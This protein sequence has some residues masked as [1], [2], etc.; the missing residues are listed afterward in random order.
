[1]GL[2][3]NLLTLPLDSVGAVDLDIDFFSGNSLHIKGEGIEFVFTSEPVFVDD[4][5]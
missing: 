1:L 4:F 2:L 5:D 3:D